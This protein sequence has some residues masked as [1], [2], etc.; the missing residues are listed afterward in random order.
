MADYKRKV[1]RSEAN[2][3][4]YHVGCYLRFVGQVLGLNKAGCT[5]IWRRRSISRSIRLKG[6]LNPHRYVYNPA[7]WI[8]PLGLTGKDCSLP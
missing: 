3:P 8:G 4:D 7:D 2:D 6:G 5:I 1:E